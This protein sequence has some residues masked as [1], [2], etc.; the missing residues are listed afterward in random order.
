LD[1]YS[2]KLNPLA[3]SVVPDVDVANL[4]QQIVES[5]AVMTETFQKKEALRSVDEIMQALR[6]LEA[7][8]TKSTKVSALF[9]RLEQFQQNIAIQ[10][11]VVRE[12]HVEVG[13]ADTEVQRLVLLSNEGKYNAAIINDLEKMFSAIAYVQEASVRVQEID[14]KLAELQTQIPNSEEVYNL[15]SKQQEEIASLVATKDLAEK[16][17]KEWGA[18]YN[19]IAAISHDP[20]CEGGSCPACGQ[21]VTEKEKDFIL[22]NINQK[23]AVIQTMSDEIQKQKIFLNEIQTKFKKWNDAST[24]LTTTKSRE[25]NALRNNH[26]IIMATCASTAL[27]TEV[28]NKFLGGDVNWRSDIEAEIAQYNL[29]YNTLNTA[30]ASLSAATR[31]QS[32]NEYTLDNLIRDKDTLLEN[33][34]EVFTAHKEI[35]DRDFDFSAATS[36]LISEREKVHSLASLLSAEQTKIDNA[37][38][39]I[40]GYQNAQW[41]NLRTIQLREFV[42]KLK[43]GFGPDGIPKI[44]VSARLAKMQNTINAYLA[45]FEAPFTTTM[46]DGLDFQCYFPGMPEDKPITGGELS[47]GQKNML[48]ISFRFAA[49]ESLTSNI[50]LLVLDEPSAPIDSQSVQSFGMLLESVRELANKTGMQIIMP[51]HEEDLVEHFD[52]TVRF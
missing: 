25:T 16:D 3:A 13:M 11:G 7:R 18:I 4:E 47:E 34:K 52:Q 45:M 9:Q 2:Y 46:S 27:C 38:R 40:A 30:R 20:S 41:R 36:A 33:E 5:R 19:K 31:N 8:R 51:T 37:E 29:N 28:Y 21:R 44:V 24:S 48:A 17:V 26:G 49:L 22:Q 6:D 23:T 10:K 32:R 14:A 35:P 12:C 15:I 39:L 42:A 1:G 43:A 50:G